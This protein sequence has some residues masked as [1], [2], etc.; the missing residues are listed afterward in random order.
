MRMDFFVV[1]YLEMGGSSLVNSSAIM[2][3]SGADI[4]VAAG[5][6]AIFRQLGSD[7]WKCIS[8]TRADGKAV[9][10]PDKASDSDVVTGTDNNKFVTSQGVHLAKAVL[11]T[12]NISSS[13]GAI[14]MTHAGCMINVNFGSDGTVLIPTNS[15]EPFYVGTQILFRQTDIGKAT[16]TPDTG[17]TIN[18]VTGT[19]QTSGQHALCTLIK[20]GTDEWVLGGSLTP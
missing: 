17:V 6:V 16:F 5:D 8:Y 15:S 9:I 3:P 7:V 12:S 18:S 10:A 13:G 2:L 1:G 19:Y 14:S 4:T 20:V 11:P